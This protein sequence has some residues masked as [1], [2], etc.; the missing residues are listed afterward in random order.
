MTVGDILDGKGDLA[1]I[2]AQIS[3]GEQPGI[4]GMVQRRPQY[5]QHHPLWPGAVRGRTAGLDQRSC[6]TTH[7]T[8]IGEIAGDR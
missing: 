3:Q 2:P 8:T 1:T 6:I 5:R 4:Q 7:I